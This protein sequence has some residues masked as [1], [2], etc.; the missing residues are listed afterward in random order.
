MPGGVADASEHFA[1]ATLALALLLG[2]LLALVLLL[3]LQIVQAKEEHRHADALG[4]ARGRP[5]ARIAVAI[6]PADLA[7]NGVFVCVCG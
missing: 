3:T 7:D 4:V 6:K 2:G 1:A 5:R